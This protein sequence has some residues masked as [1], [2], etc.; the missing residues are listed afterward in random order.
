MLAGPSSGLV[1]LSTKLKSEGQTNLA[2]MDATGKI[3]AL[4][5]EKD[6]AYNWAAAAWVDGGKA[7]IAAFLFRRKRF[8]PRSR[9]RSMQTAF[10]SIGRRQS[11]PATRLS[12]TGS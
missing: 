7:I 8:S 4:T 11:M 1:A 6:P 12:L 5:A 10:R 3:R 9:S 2:V